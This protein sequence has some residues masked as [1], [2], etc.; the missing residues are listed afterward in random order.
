MRQR[1]S[2]KCNFRLPCC[3]ECINSLIQ[4]YLKRRQKKEKGIKP[5]LQ[6]EN[7]MRQKTKEKISNF[8]FPCCIEYIHSLS[9][10]CY[11]RYTI[12][13]RFSLLTF[14]LKMFLRTRFSLRD[15]Y[16]SVTTVKC[17]YL[18]VC[19]GKRTKIWC[20]INQEAAVTVLSLWPGL[21]LQPDLPFCLFQLYRDIKIGRCYPETMLWNS[22]AFI[23]WIIENLSLCIHEHRSD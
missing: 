17:S 20:K 16:L 3:T 11:F 21:P 6:A 14:L 15:V 7:Q 12:K 9:Q 1:N 5:L 19:E 23:Y 18:W 4:F 2:E 13:S 10:F 22:H 8:R